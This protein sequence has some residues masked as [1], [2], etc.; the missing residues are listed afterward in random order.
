VASGVA[1]AG[2]D[3]GDDR[4]DVGLEIVDAVLDGLRLDFVTGVA[5]RVEFAE[6]ATELTG[7]GLAQERVELLDQAGYGGL[8]VHGL[9]RQR[10]E[11]AAQGR[12]HPAGQVQVALA[13]R[14]PKC[15]LIAIIFCWPMKPCQHRGTACTGLGSAS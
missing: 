3:V 1:E 5:G 8:L 2:V 13:L 12:D 6:Q 11:L 7:V 15:F 4:H 10:A 9:V 14:V